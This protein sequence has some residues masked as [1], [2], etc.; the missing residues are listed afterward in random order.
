MSLSTKGP[1]DRVTIFRE[2]LVPGQNHR[3]EYR[4]ELAGQPV[5]DSA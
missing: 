2:Q 5:Q 1:S 4:I 3:G